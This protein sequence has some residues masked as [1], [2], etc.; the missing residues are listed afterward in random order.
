MFLWDISLSVR[1]LIWSH[2]LCKD[3]DSNATHVLIFGCDSGTRQNVHW[4]TTC[5]CQGKT[6]SF[7][8]CG[9][10]DRL[11]QLR[12]VD[13]YYTEKRK[14]WHVFDIS[15]LIYLFIIYLF[16]YFHI[17]SAYTCYPVITNYPFLSLVP[18]SINNELQKEFSLITL[19]KLSNI[20]LAAETVIPGV[21]LN[22]CTCQ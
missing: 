3:T 20:W 10:W 9:N 5:G 8:L 4:K 11:R 14:V 21:I 13:L 19:R 22:P 6:W 2:P 12:F 1:P 7:G 17:F 18:L 16:F 15:E